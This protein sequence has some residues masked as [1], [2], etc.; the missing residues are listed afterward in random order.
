MHTTSL[1]RLDLN[2][3]VSLDALLTERSVTRAAA[4]LGLSQPALSASLSRLRIH[5]NDEIL[6]RQGNAYDLTPLASRLAEQTALALDSARRVFSTQAEWDPSESNREFTVFGSDY[7]FATIGHLVTNLA[8]ERAPDVRFRFMQHTTKFIE[9]VA[10]QL[11]GTD[12]LIV[13]HGF[14]T[15]LPYLDIATDDW[16]VLASAS[17]TRIGGELTMADVAAS[18]WVFTYQSRTAF[19]SAARQMQQLGVEPRV[20]CVVEGFLAMP[21]F[22][23]GTQRL[24]LIQ[25]HLAAFALQNPAIRVL[26]CPFEATP[27]TEALWWHPIHQRDPEHAW[28]R[29]LFAEVGAGLSAAR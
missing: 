24:G 25:S 23:A 4:R 11:R 20:E 27:I 1:A 28:M 12:A 22:I 15:D 9:D 26:E 7:S 17:N 18:P 3:L 8:A 13:P 5:F 19:T 16:V 10:T 14:L 29:A 21:F 2:L 6:T